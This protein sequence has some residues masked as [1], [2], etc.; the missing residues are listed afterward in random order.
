M[1]QARAA[2]VEAAVK[3]YRS[4]TPI[5]CKVRMDGTAGFW[6]VLHSPDCLQGPRHSR[7]NLLYMRGFESTVQAGQTPSNA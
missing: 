4:L 5:L 3:K 2:A 6:G 7:Q 1:E